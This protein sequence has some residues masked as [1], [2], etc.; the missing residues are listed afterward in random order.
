MKRLAG[1]VGLTCLLAIPAP[2]LAQRHRPVHGVEASEPSPDAP[3]DLRG[4]FGLDRIE[5][6]LA[7]DE[8]G[9]VLRAIERARALGS[10][11]ALALIAP[12]RDPLAHVRTDSRAAIALARTLAE[13][14]EETDAR[15]ALGALLTVATGGGRREERSLAGGD[16]ERF[17][18]ARGLAAMALASSHESEAMALLDAARE[19]AG[20]SGRA[21]TAALRAYPAQR[22]SEESA[23][24]DEARL[25]LAATNGDLRGLGA[26]GRQLS[27]ALASNEHAGEPDKHGPGD[28]IRARLLE[29]LAT[30]GDT[31]ALPLARAARHDESPRVRVAAT[32]VLATFGDAD[33]DAACAELVKDD[34]TTRDGIELARSVGRRSSSS[35]PD[36]AAATSAQLDL[37][38]AL[39]ARLA[40]SSD[41][42]LRRSCV[43]A[44]GVFPA[45]EAV[46]ALAPFLADPALAVDA[47]EALAR[48][49]LPDA[50]T[51]LLAFA[52]SPAPE[53]KRLALRAATMRHA[54][55]QDADSSA[56][57]GP[58]RG[59]VELATPLAAGRDAGDRAVARAYLV[60]LGRLEPNL[61]LADPSAEVRRAVLAV[62]PFDRTLV[63]H[64]ASTD[65]D[66]VVRMLAYADLE[67]DAP[68]QVA[69]E[70]LRRRLRD[71]EVD[72]P[73]A[74]RA[75]AARAT[76]SDEPLLALLHASDPLVRREAVRGLAL[77]TV[78]DRSGRL[79]ELSESEPDVEVRRAAIA[80]LVSQED[81]SA[82]VVDLL[83]ASA[84]L[85]PDPQCRALARGVRL[86]DDTR[87]VAW[88]HSDRR[89]GSVPYQALL[90]TA[91]SVRALAFDSDGDAL[92]LGV[93]AGS[94][95]L[96]LAPR[97][98]TYEAP[99]P[100]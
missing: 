66:P 15:H 7:Q 67:N 92:V 17:E 36:H 33:A 70:E 31:R 40:A 48:S 59:F 78:P 63:L 1:L 25:A 34:A 24:A 35:S 42:D 27:P 98:P 86:A 81:P 11:E 76:I 22:A 52:R 2:A 77:S 19:A 14:T 6:L 4:R 88:L 38:K 30:L 26:L 29:S 69:S 23:G 44:L 93:S 83:A 96:R 16:A 8:P 94:K 97:V 39:A 100:R 55:G 41:V 5:S 72:A 89:P 65:A 10:T 50:T 99:P 60:V 64:A 62:S 46:A 85:D 87:E 13:H 47:A 82:A 90:V 45:P 74:A 61:A 37:V 84:R 79:S 9:A 20:P 73:L 95:Q 18:L 71:G 57:D 80:G 91:A 32:R 21:A 3:L 54:L 49:P 75:L 68:E 51:A 56:G 28:A 53:A 58:M 12:Q 43:D